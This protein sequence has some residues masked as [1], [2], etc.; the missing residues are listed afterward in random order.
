[1]VRIFLFNNGDKP[2]SQIQ[3]VLTTIELWN[4]K[5]AKH[6]W[7]LPSAPY[8]LGVNSICATR[9]RDKKRLEKVGNLVKNSYLY[10]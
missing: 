1:M 10:R 7:C 2:L 4:V 9:V 5:D 8:V 6:E 3:N